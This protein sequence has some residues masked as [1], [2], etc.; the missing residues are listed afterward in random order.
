MKTTIRDPNGF[1]GVQR[2][3][4][5]EV[6]SKAMKFRNIRDPEVLERCRTAYN[7]GRVASRLGADQC[8]P[9]KWSSGTVEYARWEDGYR[10]G[11]SEHAQPIP[12]GGD[13]GGYEF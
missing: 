5:R 8:A 2:F 1:Q 3:S 6:I 12:P 10:D 11:Q 7:D 13:F 9:S 4:L